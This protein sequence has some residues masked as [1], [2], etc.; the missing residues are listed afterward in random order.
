MPAAGVASLFSWSV[1]LVFPRLLLT[2]SAA[3]TQGSGRAAPSGTAATDASGL[4]ALSVSVRE[5]AVFSERDQGSTKD[6]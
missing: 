2:L 3:H 5:R 4:V 1:W 6:S